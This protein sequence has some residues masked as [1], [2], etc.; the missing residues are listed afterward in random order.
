MDGGITLPSA[1]VRLSHATDARFERFRNLQDHGAATIEGNY[2]PGDGGVIRVRRAFDVGFRHGCADHGLVT[3]QIGL[4]G[5]ACRHAW[6][7]GE[8]AE[9]VCRGPQSTFGTVLQS[10]ERSTDGVDDRYRHSR[11]GK[12]VLRRAAVAILCLT[13][14]NFVSHSN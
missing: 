3:R 2:E 11:S 10:D 7:D 4:P 13:G 8:M 1:A 6:A 14:G 12:T 9:G 5:G